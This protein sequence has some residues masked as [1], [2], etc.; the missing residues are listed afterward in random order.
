[1]KIDKN[2]I[3]EVSVRKLEQL[4]NPK[5]I[6]VVEEYIKLCNPAKVTVI[7]DDK[8]D[9]DYIRKL[10]ITN[11]EES[12]LNING[13]TI[14]Y[15]S[16]YDQARDKKNTRVLLPEGYV[17]SKHIN[18]IEKETGLK[19]IHEIMENIMKGKEALIRFFCLGPKKSKFS[20]LALQIT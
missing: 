6:Q 19:E 18:T 4:E 11:S 12:K 3:D 17:T 13:H 1:M 5:I 8:E 10:C 20:N 14:H 9:I 15:D 16:Y 7:S 2:V